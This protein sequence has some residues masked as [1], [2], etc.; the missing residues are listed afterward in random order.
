MKTSSKKLATDVI[1]AL[2]PMID[3]MNAM[4]EEEEEDLNLNHSKNYQRSKRGEK[5]AIIQMRL[6]GLRNRLEELEVTIKELKN[7]WK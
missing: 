7:A 2:R 1:K 6:N 3:K 4:I 5:D